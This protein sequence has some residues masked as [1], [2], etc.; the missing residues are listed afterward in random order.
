MEADEASGA[1]M[2][3]GLAITVVVIVVLAGFSGAM[4][5]VALVVVLT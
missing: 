5:D 1:T 2:T 4:T 3:E